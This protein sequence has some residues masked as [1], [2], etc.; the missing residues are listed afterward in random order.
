MKFISLILFSLMFSLPNLQTKQSSTGILIIH[1]RNFESNS[2]IARIALYSEANKKYFLV[3]AKFATQK[4]ASNIT[5]K[6][7]DFELKDVTFGTYAIAIHHDENNDGVFN[8][9]SIGFPIE[10]YGVSGNK[11]TFGRP[12]FED[13]VFVLNSQTKEMTIDMK[14]LKL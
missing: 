4:E 2:G 10:G 11:S 1:V 9:S 6:S 7:V 3:N 5:Q 12:E 14:Y 8:R 13:C